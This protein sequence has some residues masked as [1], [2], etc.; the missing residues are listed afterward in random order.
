MDGNKTNA[1]VKRSQAT[2][3]MGLYS[4]VLEIEPVLVET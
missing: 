4:S 3:Q 2:L 1:N